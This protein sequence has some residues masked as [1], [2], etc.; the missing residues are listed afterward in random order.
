MH[1]NSWNRGSS[2]FLLVV[3]W[4]GESTA[5]HELA[6]GRLGPALNIAYS[7]PTSQPLDTAILAT[8]PIRRRRLH[9]SLPTCRGLNDAWAGNI[10][11]LRV[12]RPS[13]LPF[14]FIFYFDHRSIATRTSLYPCLSF[15]ATISPQY[16]LLVRTKSLTY[17][18]QWRG[19]FQCETRRKIIRIFCSQCMLVFSFIV[20]M[21]FI[22]RRSWIKNSKQGVD[23]GK[24]VCKVQW[25]F[26]SL[27]KIMRDTVLNSVG[28]V[29]CNR[30]YQRVV[31]FSIE[32]TVLQRT[33][34]FRHSIQFF[35]RSYKPVSV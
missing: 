30:L 32:W 7:R 27:D 13:F 1:R 20:Q 31:S 10:L 34:S 28:K 16:H 26:V 5:Q 3:V 21:E 2:T 18:G 22:R 25:G 35:F 14:F 15:A 23:R 12:N 33:D 24:K 6:T 11:L 9:A 4:M 8:R 29:N 17:T 19:N